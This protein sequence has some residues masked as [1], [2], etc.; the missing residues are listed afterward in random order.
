MH[1]ESAIDHT[2]R[3]RNPVETV[4]PTGVLQELRGG[5]GGPATR[6]ECCPH[7]EGPVRRF[8]GAAFFANLVSVT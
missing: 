3:S 7:A 2:A 6:L 1:A 8:D 4:T 5:D